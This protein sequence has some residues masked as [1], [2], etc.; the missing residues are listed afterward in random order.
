MTTWGQ[1]LVGKYD[2]SINSF[3][4]M[5]EIAPALAAVAQEE[6]MAEN[7]AQKEKQEKRYANTKPTSLH[8]SHSKDQYMT[9]RL[10]FF[11]SLLIY[12]FR[13]NFT[14]TAPSVFVLSLEYPRS[15]MPNSSSTRHSRMCKTS[16]AGTTCAFQRRSFGLWVP[17][18]QEREPTPLPSCVPVASPTRP[19]P[20][21]HSCP[22]P[23]ARTSSTR[24]S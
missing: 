21:P 1:P 15:R 10:S 22:H 20:C 23:S 17:Q 14:F 11:R 13:S 19:S 24:D 18:V 5:N 9:S 6:S 3:M 16:T 12:Y 7:A 4:P 2:P 8:A